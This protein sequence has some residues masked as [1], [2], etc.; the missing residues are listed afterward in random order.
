MRVTS[1]RKDL[2]SSVLQPPDLSYRHDLF[3][4]GDAASGRE[5][6]ALQS[7][8]L[9]PPVNYLRNKT[10]IAT[11]QSSISAVLSWREATA[12]TRKRKKKGREGGK[13]NFGGS[14]KTVLTALFAEAKQQ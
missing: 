8:A 6:S 1:S 13:C 2:C 3:S 5:L 4:C 11:D 12:E 10:D 14:R 9:E 7:P